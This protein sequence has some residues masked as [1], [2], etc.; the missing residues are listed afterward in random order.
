MDFPPLRTSPNQCVTGQIASTVTGST[1][2]A[3][4]ACSQGFI[5]AFVIFKANLRRERVVFSVFL[6]GE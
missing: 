5:A 6:A 1:Q 3:Q 4:K 2:G